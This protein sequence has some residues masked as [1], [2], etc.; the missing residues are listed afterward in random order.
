MQPL[1]KWIAGFGF[2]SANNKFRQEPNRACLLNFKS[3][4]C[5]VRS[6]DDRKL[7]TGGP[8]ARSDFILRHVD[9]DGVNGYLAGS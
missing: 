7:T 1:I 6:Q 9:G 5:V 3:Y 8:K 2:M 4:G